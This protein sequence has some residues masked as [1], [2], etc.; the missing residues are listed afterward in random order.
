MRENRPQES[1]GVSGT[2]RGAQSIWASV[3]N[4]RLPGDVESLRGMIREL[5]V[6]QDEL[7]MQNRELREADS[8]KNDFFAALSHELRIPLTPVMAL[9]SSMEHD[10]ALPEDAREELARMRSNLQ[11]ESKLIDDLLDVNRV[12]LGKRQLR[13]SRVD[14]HGIV[15]RALE[16]VRLRAR[17]KKIELWVQLSAENHTVCGDSQRLLQVIWNLL[18][19]AV[20]F[21]PPG[22]DVTVSSRSEG[23]NVV[24]EVVDS[25]GGIPPEDM[26]RIFAPFEP[27][28]ERMECIGG[29]GLGLPISRRIVQLHNGVLRAESDPEGPGAS[30]I[31]ELPGIS[32]TAEPPPPLHHAAPAKARVLLVEDDAFTASTFEKLLKLRGNEVVVAHSMVE[33]MARATREKFDLL[34]SDLGLPD[35]SGHDIMRYIA[36]TG[37]S[38]GIALSGYGMASDIEQS[39]SAGFSEHLTKP[40]PF[41]ELEAAVGRVLGGAP[42]DAGRA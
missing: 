33:A 13:L 11:V 26:E 39:M 32:A 34:I 38:K 14:M 19:N 9:L 6:R 41:E 16:I 22:G 10:D 40:V 36:G 42:A 29:F 35:G 21:T 27:A 24:I 7:E 30:F 3:A 31:V 28:N 2:G 37:D 18:N 12:V 8:A 4:A 20:D 5:Q 23:E 25:G 15:R 17:Q 1:A